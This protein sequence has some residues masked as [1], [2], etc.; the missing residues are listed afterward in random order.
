VGNVKS[1]RL[2]IPVLALSLAS[3]AAFVACA[4]PTPE[5]E[6]SVDARRR[7]VGESEDE[8]TAASTSK[9]PT[10]DAATPTD[11]GTEA[12]TATATSS[13]CADGTREGLLDVAAFPNVAA[14]AGT[15]SGNVSNARALCAAGWAPC[16]GPSPAL[17]TVTFTAATTFAGCFALDTAHDSNSCQASCSGA[18]QQ[19]IDS[20]GDID[21]GGIGRDCRYKDARAAS[22]LGAGRI[23]ASH[24]SNTGCNF[25]PGISGVACCRE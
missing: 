23:D 8:S 16:Q 18:V 3:I 25:A 5:D 11:G 2:S 15:W 22:C 20:A 9:T 21:M 1:H 13:G 6:S 4:A 17:K 14:C 19:G 10:K 24:N 12:A 7:A